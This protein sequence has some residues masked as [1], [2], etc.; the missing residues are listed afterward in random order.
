MV[1]MIFILYL[2]MEVLEIINTL[3][4]RFSHSGIVLVV[5]FITIV[6]NGVGR[7]KGTGKMV[8]DMVKELNIIEILR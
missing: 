1:T 5:G 6:K 3:T 2:R 7:L 4:K 8:N